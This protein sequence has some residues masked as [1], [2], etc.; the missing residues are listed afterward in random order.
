MQL[1]LSSLPCTN[2][3]EYT[4][5]VFMCLQ[6]FPARLDNRCILSGLGTSVVGATPSCPCPHVLAHGLKLFSYMPY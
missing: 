3:R 1:V 2:Y 4:R 6:K 5:Y